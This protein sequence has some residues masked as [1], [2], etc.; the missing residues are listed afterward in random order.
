[1]LLRRCLC[2][3]LEVLSLLAAENAARFEI[4]STDTIACILGRLRPSTTQINADDTSDRWCVIK[5]ITCACATCKALQDAAGTCVKTLRCCDITAGAWAS[6]PNADG[7]LLL[8][9]EEYTSVPHTY[10]G[11]LEDMLARAPKDRILRF[12]LWNHGTSDW[13]SAAASSL[14]SSPSTMR[15]H[16]VD[17]E[18]MLQAQEVDS[19][20]QCLPELELAPACAGGVRR[21]GGLPGACCWSPPD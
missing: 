7:V 10:A 13:G 3:E 17:I 4:L 12:T 8:A 6:F 5:D 19:L 15:L 18:P 11:L 21:G 14:V 9:I 1:M 2:G 16:H 20:L